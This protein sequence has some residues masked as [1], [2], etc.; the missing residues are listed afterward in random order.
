ML[1]HKN[2]MF[3][4]WILSKIY[5]LLWQYY[6]GQKFHHN[7]LFLSIKLNTFRETIHLFLLLLLLFLLLLL[8][9]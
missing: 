9:L 5:T 1:Y 7:S 6:R 2:N 8:L 3:A 4:L